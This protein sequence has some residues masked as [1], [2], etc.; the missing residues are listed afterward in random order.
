MTNSTQVIVAFDTLADPT[1]IDQA[2]PKQGSRPANK[3]NSGPESTTPM[4]G[5]KHGSGGPSER[6]AR[7]KADR[8]RLPP[9]SA[10]SRVARWLGEA[11]AW[12]SQHS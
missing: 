7:R 1:I 9:L 4:S 5:H 10:D 8:Q 11:D 3:A 6:K 2:F 12:L